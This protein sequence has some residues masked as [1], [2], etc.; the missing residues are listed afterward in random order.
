MHKLAILLASSSFLGCGLIS[1]AG[2]Q[3]VSG[4]KNADLSARS[5]VK[6]SSKGIGDG[7]D[8]KEW[9]PEVAAFQSQIERFQKLYQA[10]RDKFGQKSGVIQTRCK[11]YGSNGHRNGMSMMM[12]GVLPQLYAKCK[13]RENYTE[14]FTYSDRTTEQGSAGPQ[15]NAW[16]AQ[17]YFEKKNTPENKFAVKG[18][19][20]IWFDVTN[21]HTDEIRQIFLDSEL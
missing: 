3:A 1:Q 16:R 4:L 21:K 2:S 5:D 6:Y 14:V 13:I 19:M 11:Y 8:P 7:D 20:A 15:T 10:K 9:A 12:G 17:K 18:N